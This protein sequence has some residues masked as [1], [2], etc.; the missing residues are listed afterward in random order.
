VRVLITGITGFVGPYLAEHLI[1]ECPGM[2][3]WGLVWGSEGLKQLRPFEGSLEL[4]EGDLRD[5]RSLQDVLARSRP[6]IVYHLAAS[7]SV[8]GSWSRPE[9]AF[10]VNTI[11]Q[12]HLFE[13]MRSIGVKPLTVVSSSAEVYGRV[14]EHQLPMTEDLPLSPA[15]PYGVSKA[16][17]D[18]LAA[19]YCT[20]FGLP[21]IR[22]RLFNHTGPRRSPY[23]VASGFAR[24]IAEIELGRRPPRMVVGNLDAVRDFSDVRDIVH[25]YR[26]AASRGTVGAAYNIC[27]GRPV[28]IRQ[29]LD[30]LL[31]AT[32]V[33][34]EIEVD[35]QRLR[36]ADIPAQHGSHE[37]FSAATGW[38]PKL[39]LE[40]TLADLLAWW[41]Q[42]LSDD[43]G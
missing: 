40:T 15:S 3:L 33:Q 35:P 36:P 9:D 6:D 30:L 24:Q 4:V 34:V 16:A 28:S 26:L 11:G 38:Q 43:D 8:S 29:L 13:A 25:A 23:F 18:M 22:L 2:E 32:A 42:R 37:H 19:Q 31:E 17:Q 39:D 12:I 1:A 5:Q 20:A 41:R 10:H 14:A 21:S 7:S 27:S